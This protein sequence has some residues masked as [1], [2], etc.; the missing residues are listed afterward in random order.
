[1]GVLLLSKGGL[2]GPSCLWA[3]VSPIPLWLIVK[4]Y[5]DQW[6]ASLTSTLNEAVPG[7]LFNLE[8]MVYSWGVGSEGEDGPRPWGRRLGKARRARAGPP[9]TLREGS[10]P[11]CSDPTSCYP[12]L[13]PQTRGPGPGRML[14][15]TVTAMASLGHT[16]TSSQMPA[17]GSSILS[18]LR[19]PPTSSGP[20]RHTHRP[21]PGT[22]PGPHSGR[23]ACCLCS[24][25]GAGAPAAPPGEERRPADR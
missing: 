17:L 9:E 3:L 2:G 12:R 1:M 11:S 24:G 18:S 10:A 7:L 5:R 14:S 21:R 4:D 20:L 8:L 23:R 25:P 22:Q 16:L 19:P 13:T 6:D 15:L